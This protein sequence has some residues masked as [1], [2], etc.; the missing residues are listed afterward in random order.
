L[1]IEV[2]SGLP[3]YIR[4][5]VLY[6]WLTEAAGA[7][8]DIRSVHV[9]TLADLA[10]TP[11]SAEADLPYGLR[12]E[13]SYGRMRLVRR[14]E[15]NPQAAFGG[16]F[17]V[18]EQDYAVRQFELQEN[19]KIPV[20]G[21]TKW[22]DYD[23]ISVFPE[24]RTRQQGDIITIDAVSGKTKTLSR[25][26]IDEKIDRKLR[27][28]IVLPFVGREVLWIPGH[29]INAGYG[30]SAGTKQVLEISLRNPGES[31]Q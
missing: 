15:E 2:L 8:K 5:Q 29:R 28:V 16:G 14:R 13:K 12:A 20:S 30:I 6:L 11:G 23:K 4:D 3:E 22:F 19:V 27:D 7:K 17:P 9:R 18:S 21:Y 26:M 1:D 31:P 25:Y 10:Q 24:F